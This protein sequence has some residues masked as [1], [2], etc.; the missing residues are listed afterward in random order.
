ML[1]LQMLLAI[2][3]WARKH[4]LNESTFNT[5]EQIVL[6]PKNKDLLLSKVCYDD[7]CCINN[8]L[9]YGQDKGL[10]K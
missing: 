1:V 6:K 3:Q 4:G 5:L 9:E 2:P 7:R 8:A 10:L